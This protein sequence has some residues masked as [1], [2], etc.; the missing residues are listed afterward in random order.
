MPQAS[1]EDEIV[2]HAAFSVCYS[3]QHEQAKWVAYCLRAEMCNG[4]EERSDNFRE[5]KSIRTGSALPEDYKKSSYDRGHLCPA[6][7]MS[8]NAVAMS[9]SFLMS[10]MSPQVPG[11]NRGIW[12]RLEGKAR[13][14]AVQ[15]KELYIVTAG[16]LENGLPSIG[17]NKVSVPRLY[18]K[19]LLVY[20]DSAAR[21]I[22]F[23]L[24]NQASKEPLMNYGVSIDSV[25]RLTGIDFFPALPDS[26]ESFLESALR[27]DQWN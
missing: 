27:K 10:N 8:W 20:N 22:G 17:M 24:P 15:S 13:E 2:H 26:L 16:V 3:E 14:W 19:V 4:A 25:E 6:G 7:D 5:D 23:V 1:G 12:K 18:Y 11:F 9:E 21:A